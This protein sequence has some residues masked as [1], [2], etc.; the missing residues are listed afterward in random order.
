[1]KYACIER[2][3]REFPVRMMCRLLE[4]APSGF[5][6]WLTG[7]ESRREMD[8]RRLLVEIQASHQRSGGVYGSPRIHRDLQD[9]GYRCGRHRVARLMR[10]NGVAAKHRRKFK[11]TTDSNHPYP[12]AP[13]LLDQLFAEWDRNRAWVG[14]I[15][16]IP[17]REGWIYLAANM[18]LSSRRIVGWAVSSRIDRKLV[19][20]ALQRA[21]DL[22]DPEMGL[23]Y[24]TDRGSQ[25]ACGAFQER[26][27]GHGMIASMSRRG[28]CWDNAAMESFFHTLKVEWLGD[29]VFETRAEAERSL[30]KYIELFYNSWRRHSTL[31]MVS[32]AEY[33]RLAQVA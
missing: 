16:Y 12:V 31:G 7:P 22:R 15:T 21:V 25:Y 11:H 29:R 10:Q 33:E 19:L 30:F 9:L 8:N 2:H 20:E 6:A 1:M 23:I 4:V 26:L 5:Y 27:K 18:D 14:D 17:T 32:P 3:R 28:N 13:N 24:H